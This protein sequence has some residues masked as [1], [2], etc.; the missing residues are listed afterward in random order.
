MFDARC[1]FR[2]VRCRHIILFIIVYMTGVLVRELVRTLDSRHAR[3]HELTI[4]RGVA[5]CRIIITR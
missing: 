4:G 2:E 3:V 1:G 5:L